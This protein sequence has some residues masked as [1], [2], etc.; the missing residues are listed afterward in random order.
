MEVSRCG[1]TTSIAYTTANDWNYA[2]IA[3]ILVLAAITRP[4]LPQFGSSMIP[5]KMAKYNRVSLAI[6]WMVDL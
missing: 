5:F 2:Y 4:T 1:F 6:A 3:R